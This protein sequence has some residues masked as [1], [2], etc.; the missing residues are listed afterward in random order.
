MT[1]EVRYAQPKGDNAVVV[2]GRLALADIDVGNSDAKL[3]VSVWA[4]NL[5][6]E[7]H[8]FAKFGAPNSGVSGFFNDQRTFGAE[9]NVK[10]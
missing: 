10:F 6:N 3:T 2:N 4:R 8:V 7:Q 9:V 1:R 5:F